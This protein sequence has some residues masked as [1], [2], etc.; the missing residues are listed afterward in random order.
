MVLLGQD[1]TKAFV[2]QQQ[3]RGWQ[4]SIKQKDIAVLTPPLLAA[5]YWSFGSSHLQRNSQSIL[6]AT[7]ELDN[8]AVVIS[9]EETKITTVEQLEVALAQ[10]P[11]A[12]SR[13]IF[14]TIF[15]SILAKSNP[16]C[17]TSDVAKV[18]KLFRTMQ[19]Q[20]P[21]T[22]NGRL[23]NRE[24]Y[25]LVQQVWLLA[26]ST[27]SSPEGAAT[28]AGSTRDPETWLQHL[29]SLWD[30][31]HDAVVGNGGDGADDAKQAPLLVELAPRRS[32]YFNTF[33]G[34]LQCDGSGT[35]SVS[36]RII[37]DAEAL[38]DEML[39]QPA[40]PTLIRPDILCA[41]Q[42]LYVMT[43]LP[44]PK[45]KSTIPFFLPFSRALSIFESINQQDDL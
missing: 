25:E 1:F 28:A 37:D 13:E 20:L 24:T 30:L 11:H 41:N 10:N 5:P 21:Q 38:F 6:W 34:L 45:E 16:W 39:H 23:P 7:S 27:S 22:A 19:Q 44:Q 4:R 17:S 15:R 8:N 29:R 40:H 33:K 32:T 31:Y 26:S 9:S 2:E 35:S 43:R 14:H 3:R 36:T 18:N 12:V 42:I